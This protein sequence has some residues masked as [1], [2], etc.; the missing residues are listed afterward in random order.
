MQTHTHKQISASFQKPDS[1]CWMAL[2][3]FSTD[4]FPFFS[5]N[6]KTDSM[7]PCDFQWEGRGRWWG[8][9]ELAEALFIAARFLT[10]T[11]IDGPNKS[12]YHY[13]RDAGPSPGRPIKC[14]GTFCRV[15]ASSVTNPTHLHQPPTLQSLM[16]AI[17]PATT[18]LV[19]Y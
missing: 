1:F 7:T 18:A 17:P 16:F 19:P 10:Q 5:A 14:P 8:V 11:P 12:L 6:R 4:C 2:I 3:I 13:V 9:W 15:T